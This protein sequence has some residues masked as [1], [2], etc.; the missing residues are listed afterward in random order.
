MVFHFFLHW[1]ELGFPVIRRISLSLPVCCGELL[2]GSGVSEKGGSEKVNK[3]S[4][5]LKLNVIKILWFYLASYKRAPRRMCRGGASCELTPRGSF[6]W[7]SLLWT[8]CLL[9]WAKLTFAA[10]KPPLSPHTSKSIILFFLCLDVI[11]SIFF[12]FCFIVSDIPILQR[13][14]WP[15][16][17]HTCCMFLRSLSGRVHART[18]P[19]DSAQTH[20]S[21][22]TLPVEAVNTGLSSATA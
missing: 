16:G 20:D 2:H 22:V 10:C 1:A 12:F 8:R 11:L 9:L 19:A 13:D 18:R 15:I 14:G 21:S 3:H 7:V 6:V 17:C 5:S 4:S